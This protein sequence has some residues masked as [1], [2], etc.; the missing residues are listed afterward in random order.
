MAQNRRQS[1]Q[2]S[3]FGDPP[4]APTTP[5]GPRQSRRV[6]AATVHRALQETAGALPRHWRLGTS[7]WSFPG[8]EGQVYDREA[9]PRHLARYGL[10]AYAR[11]PL[12][13]AVG[14]DRTYYAPIDSET[15]AGYAQVVPDD[16]RFLVKAAA[17]CTD[18]FLREE[19]GR[20]GGVN[21]TFLDPQ[22]AA[23]E[24]VAP[25]VEGLGAKAGALV[26]QFP[27]L[28]SAHTREPRRFIDKLAAFLEQ[29][30]DGPTYAVE[31]RD[32]ELFNGSYSQ[33]LAA[34]GVD[35]CYTAHPRMPSL[36]EQRRIVGGGQR[37]IARWMLH[38][39]LGY[40][41]AKERYQPFSTIVDEDPQTRSALAQLCLEQFPG[42]GSVLITANN[43]AEGS[44]P[45]TLFRLAGAIVE[46]LRQEQ[47]TGESHG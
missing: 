8:W 18:P 13:R 23:D 27:P 39:G 12:L 3:L 38:P 14:I 30:P 20:P 33:A 40:E 41:A 16:F 25:Y 6:G 47:Q 2:P 24:V 36:A 15:F 44:A 34:A 42:G 11:H 37:L 35:H 19:R 29:L 5:P 32:R 43:K 28:G 17:F 1:N 4:A 45:E 26:F 22:Y 10:E 31:L 46:L 9:T 21:A 7:S